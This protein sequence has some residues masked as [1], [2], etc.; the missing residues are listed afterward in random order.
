MNCRNCNQPIHIIH[1]KGW[2][3][4][5]VGELIAREKAARAEGPAVAFQ[6]WDDG[7]IHVN[8]IVKEQPLAPFAELAERAFKAGWS[9]RGLPC[10][11]V[12]DALAC[13]YRNLSSSATS[14]DEKCFYLKGHSLGHSWGHKDSCLAARSDVDLS[15]RAFCAYKKG[16]SGAHSWE[17]QVPRYGYPLHYG[18]DCQGSSL[19]ERVS[20]NQTIV[21]DSFQGTEAC[22]AP[23]DPLKCPYAPTACLCILQPGHCGAHWFGVGHPCNPAKTLHS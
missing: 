14:S 5:C 19:A 11:P 17:L 7:M 20:S 12:G 2:C 23:C 15:V 3:P 6:R 1:I 13:G 8:G 16:H 9:A 22:D 4:L 18:S 21:G 10:N